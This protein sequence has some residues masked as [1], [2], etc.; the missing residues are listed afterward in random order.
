MSA[1]R[2][3]ASS[4][5]LR[6]VAA[7]VAEQVVERVGGLP[8]VRTMRATLAIFDAA[9]GGL[10]ANGLA[11]SALVALLP[12]LL[13]ALSLVGL[14]VDDSAAR[15]GVV[16]AIGGAV[17]PLEGVARLAL[18]QVA[19]GAVPTGIIAVVGLLWGSTRFY[20]ALDNAFGRIFDDARRRGEVERTV[21]GLILV[22]LCIALPLGAVV[23]GSI[24][25]WLLDLAPEGVAISGLGRAAWQ[26]I[27]PVASTALFIVGTALVYRLV[28]ARRL[29]ARAFVLPAVV[30]GLVLAAFTHLFTFVAPRLI[31]AAALYG[32]FV[33]AFALLAWL[34]IGFTALLICGAWTRVRAAEAPVPEASPPGP[35]GLDPRPG[36][37]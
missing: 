14:L 2:D 20:S 31:G 16:A 29:P 13:L 10:V 28:P 22:G 23:I 19:A 17:P 21:R 30:A 3:D 18:E 34:S 33:A 5:R 24:G 15:E 32:A 9:G 12:G 6:A 4:R 11:Y 1:P 8:A 25:S 7:R 36:V 35:V 27:S 37:G 26:V